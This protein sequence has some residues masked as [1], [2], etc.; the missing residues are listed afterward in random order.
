MKLP[1]KNNI[2]FLENGGCFLYY[3]DEDPKCFLTNA[4]L[5][6]ENID[7]F[8]NTK[9]KTMFIKNDCGGEIKKCPYISV[10]W[11]LDIDNNEHSVEETSIIDDDTMQELYKVEERMEEIDEETPLF[12]IGPLTIDFDYSWP[13]EHPVLTDA[14]IIPTNTALRFDSFVN[15]DQENNIILQK[16]CKK[17][18]LTFDVGDSVLTHG[19]NTGFPRI[20]HGII[21]KAGALTTD[22]QS[23]GTALYNSLIKADDGGCQSVA[24]SPFVKVDGD[25]I[26]PSVNLYLKVCFTTI[27]TFI[28][29]YEINNLKYVLVHIPP[30]FISNLQ[31]VIQDIDNVV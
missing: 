10:L 13:Q 9:E 1:K 24:I 28:S 19:A 25:I 12:N 23:I 5:E 6:A 11:D 30:N 21:M 27:L 31:D 16:E 15:F 2:L 14:L 4:L 29:E 7:I 17:R 18:Q 26:I 8:D 3:L 22:V 20:I